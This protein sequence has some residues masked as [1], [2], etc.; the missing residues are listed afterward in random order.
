MTFAYFQRR[1]APLWEDFFSLETLELIEKM[2][3]HF[4]LLIDD[5]IKNMTSIQLQ[6]V[7]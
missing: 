5:L 6:N 1:H 2:R 4:I 7:F 3:Y